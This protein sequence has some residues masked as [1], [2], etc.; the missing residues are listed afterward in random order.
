MFISDFIAVPRIVLNDN[1]YSSTDKLV[2]GVINSLSY[3]KEYCYASNSYFSKIL[4]VGTKTI[5]NSLSKLNKQNIINIKYINNQ[6]RIY[7]NPQIV[8]KENS[9]GIE[10]NCIDTMEKNYYHNRKYN[11]TKLN[12]NMRPILDID[13]DGMQTWNGKKCISTPPTK[14]DKECLKEILKMLKEWKEWYL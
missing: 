5:S 1:I 7:L 3:S 2:L 13:Q 6:R 12:K 14:E 8:E 11:K 10:K 9:K 4:N